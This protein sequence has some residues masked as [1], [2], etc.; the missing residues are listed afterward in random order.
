MDYRTV[1]EEARSEFVVDR[2]RFLSFAAPADNFE[3]ALSEV[4]RLK[5]T[6]SDATHVCYAICAPDGEKAYDDGEPKGTAGQ[7]ILSVLKKREIVGAVAVVRWF[8]GIKL[9]AGGLVEAYTKAASDALNAAKIVW[10]KRSA[11]LEIRV[12]FRSAQS[13]KAEISRYKLL[14]ESYSDA[15]YFKAAVPEAEEHAFRTA[16]TEKTLGKADIALTDY[17]Y[18][19]YITGGKQ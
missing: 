1:Q 6:Y 4:K 5:K 3:A 7:P 19:T 18:E 15:A 8:G 12:D 14:S 16:I 10:K 9:G 13:V 2:S 17:Q 11:M